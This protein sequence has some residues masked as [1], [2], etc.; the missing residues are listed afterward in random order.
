MSLHVYNTLSKRLEPFEPLD[1]PWVKM[2]VCGPT[3]YDKAHIGHAMSAIVFDVVRRYLEYRGYR[4]VHVMNFT[5]VD[6]KIINRANELGVDPLDLA[7]K[8]IREWFEHVHALNLL[9]AHYYPRVTLTIPQIIHMVQTLLDKGYAYVVDGD[10]Y[11]RVR[12]FKGYGKLSGRN[13]DELRAGARVEVDE[14]KEDPLDFALWK[15][16]KPGEPAWDSPWGPGRPGWH[17]ECSAMNHYF[18]GDQIDIHGG[19]TDLIF[20]HHENEIAQSEAYTGK[21]P[22]AKYWLHNGMLQLRGEKMSKSLGN[23]VTIDEFLA[24]HEGDVFRLIVLSSHYRKPLGY[25][26]EV[27]ADAEKALQRLRG[28]LRPP[29]GEEEE[30]DAAA[31]LRERTA[32]AREQFLAAMDDDF[33]TAGALGHIFTLVRAINTARDAGVGGSPFAQA[34]ATLLELT[35]TLGLELRPEAVA[36]DVV[37]F[38]DHLI[39]IRSELR[40]QKQWALAD[41]IRDRL[42]QLGVALED[43][44]QGTTWRWQR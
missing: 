8:Y 42:A 36:A 27:V 5:D 11:Y 19:G 40:K 1:P 9:P 25:D 3:V 37:P 44:P 21:E 12:K 39:E 28:A 2:Y 22:F 30:G 18:L 14:R 24:E 10:V 6:D 31:R 13:L 29:V 35:H 43:T 7:Q 32:H 17:I 15:A 4:V 20:P 33:N 38:I 16:A 23:L 26:D 41:R 34:Q